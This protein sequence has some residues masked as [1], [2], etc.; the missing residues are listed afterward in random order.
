LCA[1][2]Y[3]KTDEIKSIALIAL[4]NVKAHFHESLHGISEIV[5][6]RICKLFACN[7]VTKNSRN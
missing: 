1:I 3:Q 6:Y 7:D 2:T 5:Y 4:D